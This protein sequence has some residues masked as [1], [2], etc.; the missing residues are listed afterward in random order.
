[1][2]TDTTSRH[3]GRAKGGFSVVTSGAQQSCGV[4]AAGTHS[5]QIRLLDVETGELGASM[6]C[7]PSGRAEVQTSQSASL[8]LLTYGA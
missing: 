8:L 1:M 5:G 2:R 3:Q 6:L 4:L 7:R